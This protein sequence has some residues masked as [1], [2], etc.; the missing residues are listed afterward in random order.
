MTAKGDPM[1]RSRD[2]GRILWLAL[3]ALVLLPLVFYAAMIL[4]GKE[5]AAPDTMAVRPLGAWARE[6]ARDMGT[7]PLWIPYIFSG[8]PSYGS[9]VYTPASPLSPLDWILRP[10]ADARGARYFLFFLLGGFSGFALFRR[11]GFSP[12]ASAAAALCFVLTPY[13]AGCVEAGHST[14]IRALMHVPLVLWTLDLL[15]ERARPITAAGFALALAMLGWSNHPQILFYAGMVGA[16]YVLGRILS[17]RSG[18]PGRRLGVTAAWF[19]GAAAI[20]FLLIAEPT[21]AVREYAPYSIRGATEGGGATWEYATA[22]SFSPKELVSFLFPGFFGYRGQTYFGYVPFTQSTHYFGIIALTVALFGFLRRRTALGWI[23]AAISFVLLLIGFGDHLPILYGPLFKL[24]PY[25]NKFRVPS[26]VYSLLPLTIGFLVAGGLDALGTPV[27]APRKGRPASRRR[28]IFAGVA[29]IGLAV[30]VFAI[31]KAGGPPDSGFI[32][33]QEAGRISS[34]QMEALRAARSS[35]R[36]GSVALGLLLLGAFLLAVPFAR[37]LRRSTGV[38]V[39]GLILVADIWI[40][41]AKFVDFVPK[42]EVESIYRSTP[43]IDFLRGQP[44]LFRVL[45]LEDFGSNRFAAFEVATVGGYQPA[46]L[47]LYQDLLDQQ[48]LMSPPVLA[49]LNVRY[50]LSEQNPGMPAFAPVSDGVYEFRGARPRAWFVSGW[51]EL[52]DETAVLRSLGAPDFDPAATAL[53]SRGHSPQLPASA[54]PVRDVQVES[55]T[56]H[57]LRLRITDGDGPGLLIVSEIYYPVGWGA[58]VDGNPTPILQANHCLRGIVV[59]AG[60]HTVEMRF[61]SKGY[62]TGRALNRAGGLALLALAAFGVYR[63]RQ[64]RARD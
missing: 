6:A 62:R 21:L 40:V 41:G 20:A 32:R 24:M 23:W 51:R 9:Y 8:M 48:L 34:D 3:S 45:P 28:W 33:P 55:E 50:L 56:P 31:S 10:F 60:V 29:A 61:A 57:L 5:P 14:K 12:P 64:A 35:L 26:M 43:Q 49:M 44:G 11:H 22:W 4:G 30:L 17:D 47:R 2:G 19:L 38:A 16:L 27:E 58:F 63:A 7:T 59:P 1:A 53:F 52:P 39:L 13:L 54:L 46:K 36:Y 18:W 37:R 15:L 42:A 25:F